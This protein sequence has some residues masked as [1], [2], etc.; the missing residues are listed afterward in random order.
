MRIRSVSAHAFGPLHEQ[1][2]ALAEGLTVVIGDNESAKSS[3]HAAIFAALCGRRR[4]RGKPRADEQRFIDLH[5]PWGQGDWLV[6]ARIMLDD[7][8]DIELRQD[9]AGKIDCHA[10]DLVLGRDVSAEIMN[11][12][13]PDAATWLGL[14]RTTFVATACVEQGQMHRVRD[15]ADGLQD[16]LQRAAATAGAASTA[17]TALDRIADYAREHVG[18]DRANS[19]KPLRVAKDALAASQHEYEH[20][21]RAH[22]EYL[23]RVE[24]V[25]RVRGE[26]DAAAALVRAHEAAE[27]AAAAVQ[28]QNRARRAHE[29]HARHG[30]SPPPSGADGDGLAQQVAATLT[31]WRS[32]PP[33]PSPPQRSSADIQQE[34]D[35]LPA[36][37]HGDT[38]EHPSVRQAAE[39]WMRATT[40]LESY[41]RPHPVTEAAPQVS[42]VDAGDDELLDLA[43]TLEV[44]IPDVPAELIARETRARRA[45]E[46]TR[47]HPSAAVIT[48]GAVV[49]VLGLA[50]VVT[51]SRPAG[52][53][54]LVAGAVLMLAGAMHRRRHGTAAVTQELA[55]AEAHVQAAQARTAEQ[56]GRREQAAAR[57]AELGV[58][59]EPAAL[60]AIPVARARAA[61]LH[62]DH[63]ERARREA[64]TRDVLRSAAADLRDALAARGHP[65]DGATQEALRTGV[66]H[67]RQACRQRAAQGA[68]AARR[69][70]LLDQLA[71]TQAAERRVAS[72]EQARAEAAEAIRDVAGRCAIVADTAAEAVTALQEWMDQR[73][74][75]LAELG[76]AQREW[77]ELQALLDGSTPAELHEAGEIAAA[78][79]AHLADG[80]DPALL[81]SVHAESNTDSLPAL[82]Q[83]AETASARADTEDGELRQM[84][85]HL[86]SVAEAEEDLARARDELHRV[87]EL[88]ETLEL[89]RAFLEQ[90]QTREIGRAHV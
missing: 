69:T 11:D 9:L 2:L 73:Q 44:P 4:G 6:T 41:A 22:D 46:Q 47:P 39:R 23:S 14:D 67:Y 74:S 34:I 56:T 71:S 20:R 51:V 86:G 10:K 52:V 28:L 43:R 30:D 58:P 21:T 62:R 3:W 70:D 27:A 45:A 35:A 55:R 80:V 7:G 78:R 19:T 64:K 65:P 18:V 50:L 36:A 37:P 29:L 57:C 25:E 26:A 72:D 33:A 66:E 83:A 31:R 79:P 81:E 76:T 15:H 40:Q 75:R 24:E 54:A 53:A 16:H 60:R 68:Q 13:A 42:H 88:K 32:R 84:A 82:R 1:N 8:R 48:T 77:A 59:A 38:E 17:G 85:R 12:G 5:R 90:A 61:A 49:A 89:T 87:E 63:D